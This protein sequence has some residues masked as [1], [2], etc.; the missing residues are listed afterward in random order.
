MNTITGVQLVAQG[1]RA[2][3]GTYKIDRLLPNRY[4]QAV[5]PFVFLDHLLPTR[6]KA[7][8]ASNEH[9]GTGPHPH[10][11]IATLTYILNGEAE[12]YD[13]KGHHA[14]VHSG[15]VQWMKAGN[16]IVH[17]ESIAPDSLT[18]DLL[19]HSFQFW[20]NLPAKNKA[21]EANYLSVQEKDVPKKLLVNNSWLKVIAGAYEGLLSNVPA[22]S[23]QFIYH[24]H[25]E[26]NSSFALPTEDTLEYAAFLPLQ[27]A[28]V[29]D[30]EYIA[31]DLMIFEKNKGEINF[32]N[33]STSPVDVII[34][35][36]ETYTESIVAAGP[37]VMNT[38]H[39]I[40]L[41]YNDYYKGKYGEIQYEAIS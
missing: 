27:K 28:V 12:H 22:Y 34:F 6:H 38:Q 24:L 15:G 32:K 19:T 20:I 33:V 9:D 21:E 26:A 4:V 36:G 2:D 18:D 8:N 14:K 30:A 13:S 23:Q 10:R 29:N 37:F 39:E 1:K 31:N 41:A 7:I 35:G 11:G 5:G 3:I 25:L 16:G 17:D 40:S